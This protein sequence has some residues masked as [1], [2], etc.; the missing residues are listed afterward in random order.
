MYNLILINNVI[1][2]YFIEFIY[3]VISSQDYRYIYYTHIYL[4]TL[5]PNV[6]YKFTTHQKREAANQ[7]T[8]SSIYVWWQVEKH[9]AANQ[10]TTFEGSKYTNLRRDLILFGSLRLPI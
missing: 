9:S 2:S 1:K 5:F 10:K 3:I 7:K 8:S 6:I 4:K